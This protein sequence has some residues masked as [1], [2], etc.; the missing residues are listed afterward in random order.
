MGRS[1]DGKQVKN[2]NTCFVWYLAIGQRAMLGKPSKK[3]SK[4]QQH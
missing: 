1:K 3:M 4:T 2:Q